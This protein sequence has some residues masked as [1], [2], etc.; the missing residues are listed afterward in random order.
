MYVLVELDIK[1]IFD[2]VVFKRFIVY[3]NLISHDLVFKIDTMKYS[4]GL[5]WKKEVRQGPAAG[6]IPVLTPKNP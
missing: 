5:T 4:L 3:L 1:I 6:V 2:N